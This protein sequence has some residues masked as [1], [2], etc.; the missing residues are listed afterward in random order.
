M[1]PLHTNHAEQHRNTNKYLSYFSSRYFEPLVIGRAAINLSKLKLL[2][3][4]V[5]ASVG[6]P[7][8]I[9]MTLF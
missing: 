4:E 1:P 3:P 9:N 8:A 7:V 6:G 2:F 5:L